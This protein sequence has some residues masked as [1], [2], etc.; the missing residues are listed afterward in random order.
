MASIK[1]AEPIPCG[2]E[3]NT[4]RQFRQKFFEWWANQIVIPFKKEHSQ[5]LDSVKDKIA[6]LEDYCRF[7]VN[8][9]EQKT[10]A[11][12]EK[13]VRKYIKK[14]DLKSNDD[15]PL[16]EFDESQKK[17]K[18]DVI[19]AACLGDIILEKLNSFSYEKYAEAK[20]F[21]EYALNNLPDKYYHIN[22][23]SIIAGKIAYTSYKM[24]SRCWWGDFDTHKRLLKQAFSK[25]N[26]S[27]SLGMRIAYKLLLSDYSR[28][29]R[30][31]EVLRNNPNIDPYLSNMLKG[32][33]ATR[34][35]WKARGY[36]WA[37]SVS[38]ENWKKFREYQTEAAYYFRKAWEEYPECPL[39]P[40]NLIGIAMTGYTRK[41]EGQEFW[42]INMV[43]AEFDYIFGYKEYLVGL[44]PRWGGSDKKRMEL[45]MRA[46]NTKRFD[47]NVPKLIVTILINQTDY[48]QAVKW[49]NLFRKPETKKIINEIYTKMLAEK[50]WGPK[51]RE[52]LHL[53]YAYCKSWMGD[54][55]AAA[56]Q[57]KHVSKDFT[58]RSILFSQ[59]SYIVPLRQVL[60]NEIAFFT[61]KNRDIAHKWE[62]FMLS[63]NFSEAR[64]LEQILMDPK[65]TT[66]ES[67]TY[68]IHR[69]VSRDQHYRTGNLPSWDSFEATLISQ[70]K[71]DIALDMIKKGDALILHRKKNDILRTAIENC[72]ADYISTLIDLGAEINDTSTYNKNSILHHALNLKKN[73]SDIVKLLVKR[74]AD[75]N[76]KNVAGESP[77]IYA[78]KK[79]SPEIVEFLISKGAN[80]NDRDGWKNTPLM[81]AMSTDQ[82]PY[83]KAVIL[84]KH[85]AEI[86]SKNVYQKTP[87]MQAIQYRD[88]KIVK[89]LL[90]NGASLDDVNKYGEHIIHLAARY[91]SPEVMEAILD[92][93]V[94]INQTGDKAVEGMNALS[95]ALS[96]GWG[97]KRSIAALLIKRGININQQDKNG[98]T[99]LHKATKTTDLYNT[100]LILANG[101]DKTIRNNSG[102]TPEELTSNSAIKQLFQ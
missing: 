95:F 56:E 24:D 48:M 35:A 70:H 75:I 40:A 29:T 65:K 87:L 92:K 63:G 77:F 9:P 88:L 64:K 46:F 72:N 34:K 86:N 4:E 14:Q 83:E 81:A 13:T 47:T 3:L 78:I 82:M 98:E 52:K 57:I 32:N 15:D 55:D 61:G 102:K 25:E 8:S 58:P 26:F 5:D 90:E 7:K 43:K 42:F 60:E 62:H 94:D 76:Q 6:F 11:E 21:L 23:Y 99:P 84:I 18:P 79:S 33:N 44:S 27:G 89:L 69:I 68:L 74:G 1:A 80:I 71:A 39:T 45:A 59:K 73:N 96:Y 36:G 97:Y 51:E 10:I 54:Y 85:G 20:Y 67:R 38:K 22:L 17:E 16:M 12:L 19:L 31:L 30:S 50:I 91:S 49:R 53:E 101:G 66:P 37:S 28:Y 2:K 41:E 93:G 100:K